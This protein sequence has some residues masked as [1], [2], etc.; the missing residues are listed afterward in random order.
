ME[1]ERRDFWDSFGEERT[2]AA[3]GRGSSAI[4][5]VAV[6]KPGTGTGSGAAPGGKDE[7][8]EEW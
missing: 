1:P 3:K 8:W 5:T 7:G 4:G 2:E 6:K